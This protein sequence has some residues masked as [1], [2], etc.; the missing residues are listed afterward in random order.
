[1][2]EDAQGRA[3]RSVLKLRIWLA[4]YPLAMAPAWAALGGAFASGRLH[5]QRE[6]GL[7][8]LGT[9]LLTDGLWGQIWALLVGQTRAGASDVVSFA[10][11]VAP[12]PYSSSESPLSRLWRWLTGAS[13]QSGRVLPV[14]VWRAT[15]LALLLTTAMAW[16]LGPVALAMTGLALL[17]AVFFRYLS[18]SGILGAL[19]QAIFEIGLPWLLALRLFGEKGWQVAPA[20]V[21]SGFVLIQA[22]AQVLPRRAGIWLVT[23][24]QLVPLGWLIASDRS[25]MAA[26][27]AITLLAPLAAQRWLALDDEERTYTDYYHRVT[28]PWWLAGMLIAGWAAGH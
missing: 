20:V 14:A 11:S 18:A 1:V 28:G 8:L 21:A 2:V 13:S 15:V 22:G 5:W 17:I 4:Q 26:V 19:V 23:V 9:M 3:G 25:L 7:L 27:L 10:E 6:H 12:L 24:G 16:L